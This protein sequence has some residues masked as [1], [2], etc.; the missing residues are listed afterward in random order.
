MEIGW[1]VPARYPYREKIL[2]YDFIFPS[3]RFIVQLETPTVVRYRR[4]RRRFFFTRW[5]ASNSN[6]L[7][8]TA[9]RYCSQLWVVYAKC[10]CDILCAASLET[11]KYNEYNKYNLRA[12]RYETFYYSKTTYEYRASSNSSAHYI[13]YTRIMVKILVHL[14][15]H[16]GTRSLDSRQSTVDTRYDLRVLRARTRIRIR[17]RVCVHSQ[18]CAHIGTNRSN[19][20]K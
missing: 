8:I 9:I 16:C 6:R 13:R 1:Q 5:D 19:R 15:V 12:T 11:W 20:Q 7:L 14:S 17:I 4:R 10:Y 3:Q 18:L 2:F